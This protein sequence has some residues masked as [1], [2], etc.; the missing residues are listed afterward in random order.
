MYKFGGAKIL[1]NY[2]ILVQVFCSREIDNMV[3]DMNAPKYYN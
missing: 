1:T 3:M 2:I